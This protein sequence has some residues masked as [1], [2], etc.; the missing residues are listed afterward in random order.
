MNELQ[1]LFFQ[2]IKA[3]LSVD[4]I[5]ESRNKGDVLYG[6][7]NYVARFSL[8]KDQYFITDKSHDHLKKLDLSSP[9][10]LR[11]KKTTKMK[12]TY[13]HPV[14]CNLVSNALLENKD[15]E[16]F[17]QNVLIRTD[18]VTILTHEELRS[19]PK[20]LNSKM[21]DGWK[22]SNDDP[23]IRYRLSNIQVPTKTIEMK[24]SIQR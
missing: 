12:F 3:I 8:A 11:S 9:P 18:C 17:I 1:N 19:I 15:D 6:L 24:G 14:P 4:G 2:I 16:E 23:F 10:L 20:A 7:H 5:E 22:I 21:P 13:E